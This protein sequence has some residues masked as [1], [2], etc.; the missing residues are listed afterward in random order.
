[1]KPSTN[2]LNIFTSKDITPP[3]WEYKKCIV[4]DKNI[5]CVNS[6]LKSKVLCLSLTVI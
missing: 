1:M 3:F 5:N 4:D 6:Y 2:C